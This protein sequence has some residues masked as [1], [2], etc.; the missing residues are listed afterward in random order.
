[1]AQPK[2]ILQLI[3]DQSTNDTPIGDKAIFGRRNCSVSF[4]RHVFDSDV[5]EYF[6]AIRSYSPVATA[7]LRA[8]IERKGGQYTYGDLYQDSIYRQTETENDRSR[9]A[10]ARLLIERILQQL[11]EKKAPIKKTSDNKPIIKHHYNVLALD[12]ANPDHINFYSAC[13]FLKG[14]DQSVGVL[15]GLGRESGYVVFKSVR[16]EATGKTPINSSP[17][18]YGN[19][20]YANG[21][22]LGVPPQDGPDQVFHYGAIEAESVVPSPDQS[23]VNWS[24]N[25]AIHPKLLPRLYD[26]T[27]LQ[28]VAT[29]EPYITALDRTVAQIHQYKLV[30][31]ASYIS[32]PLED[33]LDIKTLALIFKPSKPDDTIVRIPLSNIM[34]TSGHLLGTN[35]HEI[36]YLTVFLRK[37]NRFVGRGPAATEETD[38]DD[39]DN[40]AP[41]PL[42]RQELSVSERR[43]PSQ[44]ALAAPAEST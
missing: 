15:M 14:A 26:S 33:E 34:I 44:P 39:D 25:F 10:L 27:V 5:F 20:K 41:H 36:L 6:V 31:I 21:F 4:L 38:D 32:A 2:E 12:S 42:Q 40:R 17:E 24:G 28:R 1:M 35:F 43:P 30:A 37:K 11:G 7:T 29:L 22:P 18:Y 3:S 13:L 9:D 19:E 8:H 16:G 23:N